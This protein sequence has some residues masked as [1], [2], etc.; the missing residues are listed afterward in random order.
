MHGETRHPASSRKK[1]RGY[2]EK[3][4]SHRPVLARPASDHVESLRLALRR[5]CPDPSH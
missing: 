3:R 1:L 2:F 5:E 4:V